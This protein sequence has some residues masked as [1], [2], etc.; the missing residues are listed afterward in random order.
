MD[1]LTRSYCC[2][3]QHVPLEYNAGV[4]AK[5]IIGSTAIG[6]KRVA[7]NVGDVVNHVRRAKQLPLSLPLSHSGARG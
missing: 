7:G 6:K 4:I 5:K 2:G 3:D 1:L